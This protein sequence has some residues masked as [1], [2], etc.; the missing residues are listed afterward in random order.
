MSLSLVVIGKIT[1]AKYRQ[2]MAVFEAVAT[3][4]FVPGLD[5]SLG[6]TS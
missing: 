4:A 3:Q 6:K 2:N 5:E 1:G